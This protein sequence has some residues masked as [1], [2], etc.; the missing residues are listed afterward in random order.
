[1]RTLAGARYGRGSSGS[2]KRSLITASWA[3]VNAPRTPKLKRLARKAMSS[4]MKDVPI[5]NAVEMSAAETTASRETSVR[6]LSRPKARGSWPCSP[7]ERASRVKPE[8]D[9]V[10]ATSRIRLR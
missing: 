8:I 3:A 6:L 4:L 1:M 7:S 2:L 5:S 9:V 10:T